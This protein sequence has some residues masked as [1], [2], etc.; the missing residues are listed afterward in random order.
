MSGNLIALVI[1]VAFA[2]NVTLLRRMHADV[3]M[4][5]TLIVAGVVSCAL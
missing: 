2:A 5:P 3:D 1:P 4:M